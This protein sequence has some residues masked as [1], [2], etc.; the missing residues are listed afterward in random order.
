M[1]LFS[2][3]LIFGGA[4]YSKE[5]CI[6]KWVGIDSRTSSSRKQTPSGSSIAVGLRVREV[7][8]YERLKNIKH[9]GGYSVAVMS[10]NQCLRLV[11]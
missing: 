3:E 6:S 5:F 10:S 8:A 4:Y 1:G 9:H 7:S 2:E 11:L